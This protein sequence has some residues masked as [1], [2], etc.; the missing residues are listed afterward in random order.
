MASPD[1]QASLR[2]HQA[3]KLDAAIA[4]YRAFLQQEPDHAEA[5]RLLGLALFAR[6]EVAP[7]RVALEH[8]MSL[9]PANAALLNDL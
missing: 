6:G 7:A 9:A 2:Q 3:G 8:A 5:N 4:G 1:L